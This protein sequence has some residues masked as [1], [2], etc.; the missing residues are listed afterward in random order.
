VGKKWIRF[1]CWFFGHDPQ[2]ASAYKVG[3]RYIATYVCVCG[4]EMK[5]DETFIKLPWIIIK[6]RFDR[7]AKEV[8]FP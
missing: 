2:L 6:G 1:C 8:Y 4:K 3:K 5:I 7:L